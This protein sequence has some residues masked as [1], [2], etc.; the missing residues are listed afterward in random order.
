LALLARLLAAKARAVAP[1]GPGAGDAEAEE[2]AWE[3]SGHPGTA[4]GETETAGADAIPGLEELA[5][6]L[7]ACSAFRQAA[8]ELRRPADGAQQRRDPAAFAARRLADFKSPAALAESLAD[9]AKELKDEGGGVYA[10]E[11]SEEAARELLS[12]G[13]RGG[14]GAPSVS[15]AKGSVRFWLKEGMLVK[16]EYAL[17]G[18]MTFGQREVDVNR[19][20][21]VE[22]KDV[23]T[24]KVEVP[25]EARAKLQ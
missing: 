24:A 18:K 7:A 25:E 13:R 9:K 10:G 11:L 21:V 12:T 16:Y 6:R 5:E 15:G 3:D 20:T 8:E 1:G 4:L 22:I 17:Q 19:T 23:G 14:Q 2:E